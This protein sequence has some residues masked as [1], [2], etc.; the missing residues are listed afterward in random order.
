MGTPLETGPNAAGEWSIVVVSD[1]VG[2]PPTSGYRR[3]TAELVQVAASLGRVRW[4]AAPRGPHEADTGFAESAGV[5]VTTVT[6]PTRKPW[7]TASRWARTSLPWAL[8][9]A[10]WSDADHAIREAAGSFDLL[11]AMGIDSYEA[12]R[13]GGIH[14]RVELID[15]DLESEKLRSRVEGA[16]D[17]G[18]V[19]RLI[20]RRDVGRWRALEAQA[21][22]K[23]DVISLPSEH[24][25]ASLGNGWFVPNGYAASPAAGEAPPPEPFRV[26][27]VGSLSYGPNHEGLGW[28][29][30]AVWPSVR[31]R[32]PEAVLRVV[33]GGLDDAHP[34]HETEGVEV[35][36]R[37]ND[38]TPELQRA[39]VAVVPI[40]WGGGTR[41]KILEAFAHGV[42]TVSTTLG[43]AGLGAAHG[44]ELLL[45]DEPGQFADA[46]DRLFTDD[47][48]RS[49]LITHG[50][51]LLEDRFD[52]A[53]IRADLRHRLD[54][55]LREG[56]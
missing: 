43:A 18:W 16:T 49:R 10:D 5:D 21:D 11:I 27:F 44:R 19:R 31:S 47:E 28:L 25:A 17:L 8:A 9:A 20:A 3:R 39:S 6:V 23:V 32:H 14:A 51:R 12:A 54:A 38:L 55:A 36:G 1:E 34:A 41:I 50:H 53:T 4:I 46:V 13:R 15:T 35:L 30:E 33:G 45:A 7:S 52:A 26:L 24:E 29:V 22:R 48:L 56:R 37:I 2:W 42:A 40:H